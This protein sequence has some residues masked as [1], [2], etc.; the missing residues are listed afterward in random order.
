[1]HRGSIVWIFGGAR[2]PA[3]GGG[4]RRA[5]TGA[6]GYNGSLCQRDRKDGPDAIR[7][8]AGRGQRRHDLRRNEAVPSRGCGNVAIAVWGAEMPGFCLVLLAA[9]EDD[10]GLAMPVD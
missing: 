4:W 3:G 1:M 6:R 7:R 8:Q 10:S 5:A 2:D 9:A